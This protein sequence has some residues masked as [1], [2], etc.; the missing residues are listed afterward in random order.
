MSDPG[1]TYRT[2]EEI[3]QMK[4]TRD[5]I[6][7]V[8]KYLFD[9]NFATEEELKVHTS[10]L[11][12][13]TRNNFSSLFLSVFFFKCNIFSHIIHTFFSHNSKSEK[14]VNK[15]WMKLLSLLRTV[16]GPLQMTCIKMS[17][18]KLFLFVLL[19]LSTRGVQNNRHRSS[20]SYS[21]STS[22]SSSSLSPLLL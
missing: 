1:T 11:H 2:R 10:K 6:L 17:M 15:L 5:P 13:H 4:E 20:S 18:L 22:T 8:E 3:Q 9:F 19:N 7:K 12:T 14:N 21:S 16:H